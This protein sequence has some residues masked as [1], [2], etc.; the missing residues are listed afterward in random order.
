[1]EDPPGWLTQLADLPLLADPP[2][3]RDG[4]LGCSA[5]ALTKRT[6]VCVLWCSDAFQC[7]DAHQLEICRTQIVSADTIC[8]FFLVPIEHGLSEMSECARHGQIA[9]RFFVY[10]LFC[11]PCFQNEKQK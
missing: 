3:P 10:A 8:I 4:W 9:A 5:S 1:M 7:I 2:P 11:L 6:C